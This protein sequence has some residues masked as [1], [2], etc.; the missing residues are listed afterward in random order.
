MILINPLKII[1]KQILSLLIVIILLTNCDNKIS[2]N[3]NQQL[4][5]ED[6]LSDSMFKTL[7]NYYVNNPDSAIIV[8]NNL[9]LQPNNL[10]VKNK[11]FLFSYL[12]EIYQYRKEN[13]VLALQ[14]LTS[15]I[16]IFSEN[17]ELPFDNPFFLVNIGNILY[18][19][20]LYQQ[21]LRTYKDA[22]KIVVIPD[23]PFIRVLLNNNI[24][25]TY[26]KLN[27]IDSAIVYF[28]SAAN[29][30]YDKNK[31]SLAQNYSYL[32]SLY[33]NNNLM[34][35]VP[36]YYDKAMYILNKYQHDNLHHNTE[37]YNKFD[38]SYHEIKSEA[39]R[40]M[41]AFFDYQIQYDSSYV[42]LIQSL[43]NSK[44]AHLHTEQAE[45]YYKLAKNGVNVN[46]NEQIE[47]YADSAIMLAQKL[48]DYN[49]L[50]K[51]SNFYK[52]YYSKQHN[53]TQA[54]IY[55]KLIKSYQDTILKQKYSDE[56]L[57][58]KINMATSSV[59]LAIGNMQIVQKKYANT[60]NYQKVI[61][62]I[63]IIL[64]IVISLFLVVFI[65]MYFKLKRT[66]HS[67][68]IRTSEVVLQNT[69]SNK[70]TLIA[71]N[72]TVND[73][74][75]ERFEAIMKDEKP[76]L[77]SNLKLSVLAKKL[78]TNQTYISQLINSNYNVNYS[79]Y[80]NNKR[81]TEACEKF[82]MLHNTNLTIDHIISQVGFKSKS[83]FYTAFRK[84]TGVSP[85]MFIKMNT[86]NSYFS[87]QTQDSYYDIEN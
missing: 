75:L 42:Y 64:I 55:D 47:A 62:W 11:I 18:K 20:N 85:A 45:I 16:K 1:L 71:E 14:N 23:N 21:A 49:S 76:Y 66:Q 68:A 43:F 6:V 72:S 56:I 79:E 81:V 57:M 35:S 19:N 51:Y 28:H 7:D 2:W 63:S 15:A 78:D 30:I 59:D 9:L 33:A 13:D 12:A 25:L 32:T 44:L 80:I 82:I 39:E 31:I 34:D 4:L 36:F 65:V 37:H 52:N 73:E 26:S 46:N 58:Q 70:N 17:P 38:I 27:Q 87:E 53:F 84:Y 60:I 61:I 24:A 69:I 74:L 41:A 67:L 40:N 77:D 48:N 50:L 3:F 29:N 10:S 83:T 86:P 22:K 5:Q 54:V 8:C